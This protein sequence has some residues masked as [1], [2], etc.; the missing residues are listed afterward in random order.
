MLVFPAA[1]PSQNESHPPIFWL[2]TG[3]GAALKEGPAPQGAAET[4]APARAG[5]GKVGR[6]AF[7][8]PQTA[9]PPICGR[10]GAFSC[11]LISPS[12]CP[13][14]ATGTA[15]PSPPQP[16]AGSG[17]VAQ[18]F[19]RIFISLGTPWGEQRGSSG[20]TYLCTPPPPLPPP[21]GSAGRQLLMAPSL[22]LALPVTSPGT[23]AHSGQCRGVPL[24]HRR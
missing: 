9:A 14:L 19:I 1:H 8:T 23:G 21:P 16:Q 5:G 7:F 12:C 17:L 10:D 2:N 6:G 18:V 4:P 3:A 20:S 24:S 13:V 11:L 15:P 22:M